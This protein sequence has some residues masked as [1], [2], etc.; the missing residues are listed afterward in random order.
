MDFTNDDNV[1]LTNRDDEI[2]DIVGT[3]PDASK[4]PNLGPLLGAN[5]KD[6]YSSNISLEGL[7]TLRYLNSTY[8][9]AGGCKYGGSEI[10]ELD[11]CITKG[12]ISPMRRFN[13][14]IGHF[15]PAVPGVD[16]SD[17]CTI[18]LKPEIFDNIKE[19]GNSVSAE[20]GTTIRRRRLWSLQGCYLCR[21]NDE[22]QWMFSNQTL[23]DEIGKELN[24]ISIS[25]SCPLSIHSQH[26][27]LESDDSKD[28]ACTLGIFKQPEETT[29]VTSL[30]GTL[31]N[32]QIIDLSPYEPDDVP[33][34]NLRLKDA[35]IPSFL[36]KGH[37][38][39]STEAGRV[40]RVCCDVYTR[41]L[42]K[43]LLEKTTRVCEM[44]E[45][46]NKG[47]K[48]WTLFYMGKICKC[49]MKSL[50]VLKGYILSLSSVSIQMCTLDINTETKVALLSISS[51][52][53]LRRDLN[54][55]IYSST[56]LY[57]DQWPEDKYNIELPT[58]NSSYAL[59]FYFSGFFQLIPYI[60]FNRP[61]RTVISSVQSQQ[62]VA[63]PYGAG[64]SSV[65]PTH[66]SKPIVSTPLLES[67]MDDECAGICDYMPGED[68]VL[69]YA[70]F[71]DTYEDSII[72][73]EGSAARGLF[74]Y[75]AYSS[76]LVRSHEKVP[77]VGEYVNMSDN[78][79]WKVYSRRNTNIP[80]D[81]GN[82]QIKIPKNASSFIA[83]GDGRG[84][85]VSKSIT[86][87]GDI[88][89]KI[90][91]FCTGVTGDK[92]ASGHGQK[93]V[94]KLWKDE[95]MP[96]GIDENGNDIRFDIIMSLSSI[97]NRL[98]NGHYYEMVTGVKAAGEGRRIVVQPSEYCSDHTETTLYDGKTGQMI[99]RNSETGE[100]PILAS[101]GICRIWQMT[102]LSW[103]KQHYTHN[104]AGKYS[105]STPVG[106][107]AGGGVKFGE[108][109]T[110][111]AA[112][113]GFTEA[114]REIK[115]R[116]DTVDI[117]I[118]ATCES[119]P[120]IC[121]CGDKRVLMPVSIPHSMLVFD[122][123]NILTSGYANRYRVTF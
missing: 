47:I 68:F 101:W 17:P 43:D 60:C 55:I 123:S 80:R 120:Q 20:L 100:I 67:I 103:D 34:M 21:K 117:N 108:M 13:N 122:Y 14:I 89:I 9:E 54:G 28:I 110:H 8:G 72:M 78:P 81:S 45:R 88:S 85:I 98:T 1:L 12:C 90:L 111:A 107:S 74:S 44:S 6:V 96:W 51:G 95:D 64:T 40:K 53:L 115:R 7:L 99:M 77:E 48:D 22:G 4:D 24:N 109:E 46:F 104:V 33:N 114:S 52:V 30:L 105:V 15:M 3:L 79:W 31:Q 11:R 41:M 92:L 16:V 65:A 62:A 5:S 25:F 66:V 87:T 56:S 29:S 82:T 102:Q 69:C 73:S 91:R 42:S 37:T 10:P 38:S 35:D 113:S 83:G 86:Q 119:I 39:H 49:S 94:L 97:T 121:V 19:L 70:N 76:S 71:N 112:S 57:A 2:E 50:L 18:C 36:C 93:G 61:P 84:K 75:M 32:N 27:W 26:A 23:S 63:V 59:R 106:R 118:C 58:E 116:I